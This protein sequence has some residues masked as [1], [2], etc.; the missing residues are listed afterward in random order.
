VFRPLAP[1]TPKP[2]NPKTKFEKSVDWFII[3]KYS[4]QKA[5]QRTMMEVTNN[6]IGKGGLVNGNQ[7]AQN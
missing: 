4:T 5:K 6:N 3:K 2:Q 7:G 1:K